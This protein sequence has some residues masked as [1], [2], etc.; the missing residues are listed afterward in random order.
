MR[1]DYTLIITA[2]AVAAA[3]LACGCTAPPEDGTLNR[4]NSTPTGES[5]PIDEILG[6]DGNFSTF[7]DAI[8]IAGLQ[9]IFTGS[10]PYTVFAPTDEAFDRLPD[11][12][13]EDLFNDPKGNLAEVLLY[14]MAP[15]R[16]TVADI[17][18]NDTVATV[19]GSSLAVDAAGG[20]ATVNGA[21][22]VRADI[23][24]S[25]GVIHVIDTVML[26]PEVTLPEADETAAEE[27][28]NTTNVTG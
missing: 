5:M 8:E 21:E 14:H 4:T 26:P 16:H 19:Q 24:A 2:V 25:N 11:A 23:P 12:V 6:R 22:L 15:G 9:G 27:T 20:V 10:G 28:G 13:M 3:V 18:A 1:T 7:I 17:A